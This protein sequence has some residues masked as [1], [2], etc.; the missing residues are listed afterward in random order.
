MKQLQKE[1]YFLNFWKI[2]LL[3]IVF[4]FGFPDKN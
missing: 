3:R 1:E 4:E 2:V